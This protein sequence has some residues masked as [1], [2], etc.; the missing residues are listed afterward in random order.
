MDKVK[1]L[2][3][4]KEFSKLYLNYKI[5]DLKSPEKLQEQEKEFKSNYSLLC[6]SIKPLLDIANEMDP[7]TPT[8]AITFQVIS[9]NYVTEKRYTEVQ[10]NLKRLQEIAQMNDP[11]GEMDR[12]LS[13]LTGFKANV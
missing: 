11:N 6:K 9:N 5:L 12:L 4:L 1:N 3:A 8:T 10:L 13:V 2:I 7:T